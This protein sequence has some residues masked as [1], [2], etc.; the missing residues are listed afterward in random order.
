[1]FIG[2]E[3][4][5]KTTRDSGCFLTILPFKV[6]SLAPYPIIS[7]LRSQSLSTFDFRITTNY[8]SREKESDATVP[9]AFARTSFAFDR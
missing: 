3:D 6:A 5:G 4:D 2:V 7:E 9:E 1:M 8:I